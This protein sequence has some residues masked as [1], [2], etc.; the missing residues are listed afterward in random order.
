ML[1][2]G[3][4]ESYKPQTSFF[5]GEFLALF[6]VAGFEVPSMSTL[7]GPQVIPGTRWN[8][9]EQNSEVNWSTPM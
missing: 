5:L 8:F 3:G 9:R 1:N 2:F 6:K 7:Q 4:G